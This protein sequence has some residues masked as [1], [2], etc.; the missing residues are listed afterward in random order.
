MNNRRLGDYGE[1][2]VRVYLE[3]RGYNIIA[4]KYVSREGEIDIICTKE[5]KLH[6]VEVK[7]RKGSGV[8]CPID[9]ITPL[10]RKRMAVTAKNFLR[11]RNY[12]V[13]FNEI[14][15]DGVEVTVNYVEDIIG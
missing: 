1:Y 8:N 7:T 14:V 6:F 15:F 2:L 3:E 9:A 12:D 11:D 4:T 5:D 13:D 10:K